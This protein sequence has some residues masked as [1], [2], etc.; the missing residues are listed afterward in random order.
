[1]HF[2]IIIS[3]KVTTTKIKQSKIKKKRKKKRHTYTEECKGKPKN[4]MTNK[5][6]QSHGDEYSRHLNAIREQRNHMI[7]E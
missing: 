3:F 2:I 4:S 6:I 7:L 1:M 5:A